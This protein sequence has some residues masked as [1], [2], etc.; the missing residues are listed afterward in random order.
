MKKEFNCVE[1]KNEI[2]QRIEIEFDGLSNEER[3]A[4]IRKQISEDKKMSEFLAKVRK[5]KGSM[6]A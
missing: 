4:K 1:M 5:G 3:T 2:Q 6:T